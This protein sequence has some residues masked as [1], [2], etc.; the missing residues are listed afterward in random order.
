MS[1]GDSVIKLPKNFIT[2]ASTKTLNQ[3]AIAHTTKPIFGLQFHP[4][5]NH[6]E[7][8]KILLKNFIYNICQLESTKQNSA[9]TRITNQIKKQ[10][11]NK[12][13]FYWFRV[14]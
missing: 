4:E 12:K 7:Y 5:V 10:V 14:E 8:G 9:L 13:F 6:P 1:H 2:L 3:A 11:G